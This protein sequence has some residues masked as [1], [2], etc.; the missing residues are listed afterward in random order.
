MAAVIRAHPDLD[1]A[2]QSLLGR[3]NHHDAA[4]NITCVLVVPHPG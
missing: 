3:A 4:D 2:V 1:V